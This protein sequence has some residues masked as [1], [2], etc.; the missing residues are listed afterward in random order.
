MLLWGLVLV[1]FALVLRC[2]FAWLAESQ[3]LSAPWLLI[4]ALAVG[5]ATWM[6]WP[7]SSFQRGLDLA[8]FLPPSLIRTLE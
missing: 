5:A 6:L 8:Q 4:I 3:L 7:G 1:L 2:L